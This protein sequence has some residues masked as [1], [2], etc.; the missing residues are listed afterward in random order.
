MEFCAN[1][2]NEE[3]ELY[4]IP[5]MISKIWWLS[6]KSQVQNNVFSKQCIQYARLI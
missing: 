4:L 2:K 3:I 5:G 1:V 6:E